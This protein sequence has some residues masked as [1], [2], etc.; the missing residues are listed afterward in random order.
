MSHDVAVFLQWAAEPEMEHRKSMGLKVMMFLVV[1]TIFFY[2]AKN[3][4]WSNFK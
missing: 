3:R 2:I 1:F 4:I